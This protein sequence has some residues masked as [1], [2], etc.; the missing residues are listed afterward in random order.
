MTLHGALSIIVTVKS[1]MEEELANLLQ[2]IEK[3]PG[4]NPLLP[5]AQIDSIHFARFVVCPA[6]PDAKGRIIPSRLVFT[7]NYDQPLGD[8]LQKLTTITGP[9]LWKIFSCTDPSP[10][11]LFDPNTLA[12]FLD[13]HSIKA[14][15]FYVG[16][17]NRSVQQIRQDSQL[18]EDIQQFLDHNGKGLE[19]KNA[20]DIREEIR[21]FLSAD[22]AA[23]GTRKPNT[24]TTPTGKPNAATTPTNKPIPSWAHEPN[25]DT[26]ASHTLARIARLSLAVI[27]FL[28]LSP[29]IIPLLLIWVLI[30]LYQELTGPNIKCS[31]EKD[32]LDQLLVRETG[33]V[34]NQ[35]SAFGDLKPGW[36]R[37]H[38]VMTLL[39]VVNFLAPYLF[40]KGALSGIPTVHFARWLIINEGR[41]ML[42]LSNYDGNSEGYLRDFI[43]IAAKQLTLLFSHTVG[44][45]RTILM[46]FG[47]AKDANGFMAWARQNQLI[48]NVWY[49]ANPS[50]TVKNIFQNARIRKGL[51]GSMTERQARDWLQLF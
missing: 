29:L 35:F 36:I 50:V 44:Y 43:D 51:Y 25:P 3:D 33:I 46:V 22:P 5:L 16:V 42:F 17:A 21:Q 13:R 39:R 4:H 20:L 10:G 9:G 30:L 32:H 45:P 49:S 15:T 7:T 40:S 23:A 18:R 2:Q 38:T 37:Y 12:A 26:T 8:H 48:T 11:G 24:A 14:N 19:T 28:A 41:Q 34:Q 47:G 31:I 6:R 27:L 1:G